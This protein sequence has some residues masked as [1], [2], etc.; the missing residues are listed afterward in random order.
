M[1]FERRR[2]RVYIAGP[3][4]LGDVDENIRQGLEWG[5]TMLRDGLAPYI[6]HLDT[7]LFG[8]TNADEWH[9]LL[10]WDLEWVSVSEAV[11]RLPGESKGADLEVRMARELSIPVFHSYG[12]LLDY[13]H[14]HGLRGKRTVTA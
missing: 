4:S 12:T 9:G 11:F 7:F 1:S 2:L 10:E 8:G 13:A 14:L 6:P 3:I 5:R